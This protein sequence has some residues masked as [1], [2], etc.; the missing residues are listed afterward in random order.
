MV[1][2]SSEFKEISKCA[3]RFFIIPQITCKIRF[4]LLFC[5]N[6]FDVLEGYQFSSSLLCFDF[7]LWQGKYVVFPVVLYTRSEETQNSVCMHTF[8]KILAL[9]CVGTC[10][11]VC[12]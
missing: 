7:I 6:L 8:T 4:L 11:W 9:I 12:L 5:V 2:K 3:S 1:I 10:K